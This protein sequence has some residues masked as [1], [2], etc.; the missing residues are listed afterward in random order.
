MTAFLTTFFAPFFPF[1]ASSF[2]SKKPI[3]VGVGATVGAR[4]AR[5]A[6]A[7]GF[8]NPS[9]LVEAGQEMSACAW[10]L[11]CFRV[12]AAFARR[13]LTRRRGRPEPSSEASFSLGSW[14]RRVS[15]TFGSIALYLFVTS[16][17]PQRVLMYEH[18]RAALPGATRTTCTTRASP[19]R[20]RCRRARPC[21]SRP[22]A[23][24]GPTPRRP[25]RRASPPRRPTQAPRSS[26]CVEDKL[27]WTSASW[28]L[29]G[30]FQRARACCLRLPQAGQSV[31]AGHTDLAFDMGQYSRKLPHT[32]PS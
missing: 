20:S 30:G 8:T 31:L 1:G 4:T 28:L 27:T 5:E 11:Q 16:N 22:A 19:V 2:L 3:T 10:P 15:D 23:A 13:G 24:A 26:T 25:S 6:I 7:D 9:H 21:G 14:C 12:C 32:S 17:I 18:S 29:R